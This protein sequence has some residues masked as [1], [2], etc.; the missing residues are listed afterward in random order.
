M[1]FGKRVT[2][3]D[4]AANAPADPAKP[5]PGQDTP[6][7]IHVLPAPQARKPQGQSKPSYVQLNEML[8]AACEQDGRIHT[9]TYLVGLGALIGFSVQKWLWEEFL[10]PGKR[11]IQEVFLTLGL[12]NG[13]TAFVSPVVDAKLTTFDISATSKTPILAAVCLP[14][15]RAGGSPLDCM[16]MVRWRNATVGG[17]DFAILRVAPANRPHKLPQ[18]LLRRLW[19]PTRHLLERIAIPPSA[20][21]IELTAATRQTMDRTSKLL[22]PT[23]CATL[24]MEAAITMSIV[25]PAT[26]PED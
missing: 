15:M 8:M 12:A 26:V 4:P 16:E 10:K 21:S 14:M 13:E 25:D 17:P 3:P 1:A 18:A 19:A 7:N 9:E 6:T 20:W 24:V 23:I 5:P 2:P 11:S 22:S